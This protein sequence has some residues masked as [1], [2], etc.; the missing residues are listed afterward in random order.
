MA[1]VILEGHIVV[2]NSELDRIKAELATHIQ[3]TKAEVGCLK[4]E[5]L[6]DL[7]KPNQFNVYEE[8]VS[9]ADFDNHQ[10][11]VKN[12]KWGRVT[13]GV[14]RHYSIRYQECSGLNKVPC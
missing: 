14:E 1:K 12:S 2:P 6:P 11:R 8:F 7:E 10:E 4:F 9:Q 3:L 5:V 13:T